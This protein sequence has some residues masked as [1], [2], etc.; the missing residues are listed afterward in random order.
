[1]RKVLPALLLGALMAS[2]ATPTD[3]SGTWEFNPGK[4]KN[5]GMMSAMQ[6]TAVIQQ[7]AAMLT[8]KDH[9]VFNGQPSDHENRYDLKGKDAPNDDFMGV[10]NVTVSHWE[11]GKLI[12]TW[13]SEGAVAG[14]K[15]VR[16]ETRSL[17][18]DG[19]TMSVESKRGS[20]PPIVMVYDK[21]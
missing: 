13:T 3:F 7:N 17:S 10:K 4:S 20:N 5:V 6:S 2:A 19:K 11:D 9:S 14:T 16:T 21:K 15:V 8:E 18:A 1:M 12:T